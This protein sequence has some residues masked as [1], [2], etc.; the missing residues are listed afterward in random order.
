MLLAALPLILAYI[1]KKKFKQAK[2]TKAVTGSY[3]ERGY[4][5]VKRDKDFSF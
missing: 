4:K 3:F 2:A 1:T 5:R